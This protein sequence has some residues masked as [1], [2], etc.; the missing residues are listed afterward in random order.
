[1][2]SVEDPVDQDNGDDAIDRDDFLNNRLQILN[3]LAAAHMEEEDINTTSTTSSNGTSNNTSSSTQADSSNNISSTLKECIKKSL[4]PLK[5]HSLQKL[6]F[7]RWK[8][9]NQGERMCPFKQLRKRKPL[10]D[11]LCEKGTVNN[12]INNNNNVVLES[13]M[14]QFN[15]EISALVIKE[16][17]EIKDIEVLRKQDLG[18]RQEYALEK[19][20]GIVEEKVMMFISKNG[21]NKLFVPFAGNDEEIRFKMRLIQAAN[22]AI[23]EIHT[24]CTASAAKL[25][26]T[27]MNLI[28]CFK[29]KIDCNGVNSA[30]TIKYKLNAFN[31]WIYFD[32]FYLKYLAQGAIVVKQVDTLTT[33]GKSVVYYIGGWVM[34]SLFKSPS[35]H[36]LSNS[37]SEKHLKSH[38]I[39]KDAAIADDCIPTFFIEIQ[40]ARQYKGNDAT[41][42]SPSAYAFFVR[43]EKLVVGLSHMNSI[44][45]SRGELIDI[46]LSNANADNILLEKA[47][48]LV[49]RSQRQNQLR[50]AE[51]KKI[52]QEALKIL[53]RKYVGARVK[54]V[55]KYVMEEVGCG[56]GTEIRKILKVMKIKKE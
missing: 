8:V 45:K 48:K 7:E 21:E 19:T 31:F 46:I 18:A 14:Q 36:I 42:I 25:S 24:S 40:E 35:L 53:A 32:A 41:Y 51:N 13:Y 5:C 34:H 44:R 49:T 54:A 6:A 26:E 52:A 2:A 29:D 17:K 47:S 39:T 4:V 1:M 20:L 38:I 50:F 43:L 12:P 10:V 9:M 55:L 37:T 30:D 33:E 56:I 15:I 22:V 28:K 16:A 3:E 23:K 27:T 11:F